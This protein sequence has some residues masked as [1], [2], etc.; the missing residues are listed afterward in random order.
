[1]NPP[2]TFIN[3]ERQRGYSIKDQLPLSGRLIPEF[4]RRRNIKDMFSRRA[5]V[6]GKASLISLS[7]QP[8]QESTNEDISS[9]TGQENLDTVDVSN[10]STIGSS[11]KK[12]LKRDG[13]PQAA[14]SYD[15]KSRP[16]KKSKSIANAAPAP[17]SKGQ[18]SLREYFKSNREETKKT[19][20]SRGSKE[21]MPI[22]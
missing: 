7:S 17:S 3:G 2:G 6:S 18:Q 10:D 11:H 15:P 8:S 4:D 21:N 22:S 20:G 12:T 5:P 19:G 14:K 9:L 16:T 13:S 1:M